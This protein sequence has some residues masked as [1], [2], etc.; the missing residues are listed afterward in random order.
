M[1]DPIMNLAMQ[2][3]L[4]EGV[5]AMLTKTDEKGLQDLDAAKAVLNGL[6]LHIF[7]STGKNKLRTRDV[8]HDAMLHALDNMNQTR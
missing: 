3:G 6:A 8:L 7:T 2:A 4:M 1:I 5:Q